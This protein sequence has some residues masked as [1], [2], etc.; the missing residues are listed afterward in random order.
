METNNFIE[1]WYNQLETVCLGRKRNRR[2]DR[3]ISV[4]VDDVEPDYID[5]ICRITLNVG[6][7]GPE[8]RRLRTKQIKADQINMECIPDMITE[9]DTPEVYLIQSFSNIELQHEIT[10]MESE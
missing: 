10:V 3:L 4:L 6:R 8:E 9:S 1:S 7:M 5:N 2:V